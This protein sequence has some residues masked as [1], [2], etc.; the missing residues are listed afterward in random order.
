MDAPK[1]ILIVEDQ[2]DLRHVVRLTLQRAA[3][4]IIEA[5]SGEQALA[6]ALEHRPDVILLDWMLPEMSG[7]QVA[8]KLRENPATSDIRIIMLSARDR[9][10]D[11]EA[12]LASGVDAYLIKPFSPLEL[13]RKVEE[14]L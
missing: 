9:E 3:Y 4:R 2:T 14:S 7:L 13:V 12:G 5:E 10:Q 6:M 8:E 1:T 11:V